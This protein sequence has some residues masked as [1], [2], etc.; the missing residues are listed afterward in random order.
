MGEGAGI[1]VLESL[2]HAIDR[3]ATIYA[4]LVGYGL[5]SDAYHIT[6]PAP[7]SSEIA[8]AMR[9]ALDRAG[10]NPGDVDYINA[11]GTGTP[12]GD[13]AETKA[14]KKLS[15]SKDNAPVIS[16]T[17]SATGHLFGAAGGVEAIAVI[18]TIQNNMVPPTLNLEN[19]DPYCNLDYT[20][21]T[22]R[23]H[24]VNRALS[25]GFGFGGHN[26]VL[27]ISSFDK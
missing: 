18:Q 5:T 14:I 16:S 1:V 7:D 22:C 19:P 21:L 3:N 4:E 25:N 8:R 27:A 12:L 13:K 10:I 6:A 11:H 20:P 23:K 24:E 17:K 15:G 26:S 9:L 2:E